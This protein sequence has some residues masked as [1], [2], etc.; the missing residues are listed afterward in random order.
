MLVYPT[1]QFRRIL[2]PGLV[3]G[4]VPSGLHSTDVI[5][6][7][8]YSR[9][10]DSFMKASVIL[11]ETYLGLLITYNFSDNCS[12]FLPTGCSSSNDYLTK[13]LELSGTCLSFCRLILNADPLP[14]T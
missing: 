8:P 13:D 6:C 14:E 2:I 11:F 3:S 12:Q 1:V 5:M 4:E 9:I 10:S 7:T